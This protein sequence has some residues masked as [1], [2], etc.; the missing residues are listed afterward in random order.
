MPFDPMN[1][2]SEPPPWRP[3]PTQST[4]QHELLML[5]CAGLAAGLVLMLALFP[6]PL[7]VGA[8]LI[9]YLSAQ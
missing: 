1:F 6:L 5:I 7:I 2:G 3:D 8:N 9:D 4:G